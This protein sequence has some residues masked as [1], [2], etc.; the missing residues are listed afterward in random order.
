MTSVK[1]AVFEVQ[2]HPQPPKQAGEISVSGDT[3]DA[4][5]SAAK[6]SLTRKGYAVRNVSWAPGAK[7][8]DPDRLVAYVVK[9]ES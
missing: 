7:K 6:I 8:N 5:K 9:K 4:C 2:P 1:V 3:H